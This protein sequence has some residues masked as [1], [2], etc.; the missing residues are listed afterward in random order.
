M[1]T[2]IGA[3]GAR[4]STDVNSSVN[5]YI[6]KNLDVNAGNNISVAATNILKETK[7]GYNNVSGSGGFAGGPAGKISVNTDLETRAY[8]RGNDEKVFLCSISDCAGCDYRSRY[9]LQHAGKHCPLRC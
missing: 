4:T 8:L 5:A 3:S 7:S 9:T 2:F 6:G 1:A